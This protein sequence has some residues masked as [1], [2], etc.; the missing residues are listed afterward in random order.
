MILCP[1]CL[2]EVHVGQKHNNKNSASLKK[3]YH[4]FRH[5]YDYNDNPYEYFLEIK[6]PKINFFIET[7]YKHNITVITINNDS[8]INMKIIDPCNI[9]D[10][11]VKIVRLEAFK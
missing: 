6:S 11:L 5:F 8:P 2:K 3:D 7:Y 9:L 1:V 10:A 4:I